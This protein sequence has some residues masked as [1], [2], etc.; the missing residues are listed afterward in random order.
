MYFPL[1]RSHLVLLGPSGGDVLP[2][3]L[4]VQ[5][6]DFPFPVEAYLSPST[7]HFHDANVI[8]MDVLAQVK[9]TIYGENL[10]FA[11]SSNIVDY[12]NAY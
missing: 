2:Q 9:T 12:D 3:S 8:G 5:L 1:C 10:S 11:I 7:S 4:V 6:A